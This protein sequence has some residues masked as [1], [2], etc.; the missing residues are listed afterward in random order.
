[1]LPDSYRRCSFS[2]M[3]VDGKLNRMHP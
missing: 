3:N 2:L 1:V